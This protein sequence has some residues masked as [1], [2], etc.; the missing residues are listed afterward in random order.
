MMTKQMA[1]Q[2]MDDLPWC[3]WAPPPPPRRENAGEG[4]GYSAQF[5]SRF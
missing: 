1:K 5:I 2:S 4:T 3:N